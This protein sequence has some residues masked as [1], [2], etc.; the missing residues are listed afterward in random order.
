ME[1][2]PHRSL[3]ENSKWILGLIYGEFSRNIISLLDKLN[4]HNNI[5]DFLSL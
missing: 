2:F 5:L 4:L 1:G 3:E